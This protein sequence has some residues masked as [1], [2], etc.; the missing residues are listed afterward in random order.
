MDM[1]SQAMKSWEDMKRLTRTASINCCSES[2]MSSV[3]R[4]IYI[5]LGFASPRWHPMW[6]IF[7]YLGEVNAFTLRLK[8]IM[9]FIYVPEKFRDSFFFFFKL[10]PGYKTLLL[11]LLLNRYKIN[12]QETTYNYS[13]GFVQ[14]KRIK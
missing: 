10:I 9:K 2:L 1:S 7:V 14:M 8:K 12:I 13:V 5:S 11:L 3:T 4:G 6:S